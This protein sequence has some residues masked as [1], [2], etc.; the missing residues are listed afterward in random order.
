MLIVFEGLDRSGKT[1]LSKAFC[2]YLNKNP[3]ALNITNFEWTKE[4]LFSTEEADKLNDCKNDEYKREAL[5]FESRIRHQ[6]MMKNKNIICD[7]YIWTGLAYA[8]LFSPLTLPFIKE[9]YPNPNIILQPDLHIFVDTPIDICLER[10][11]TLDANVLR[12]LRKAFY[13]TYQNMKHIRCLIIAS[14]GP[15]NEIIEDL[16]QQIKSFQ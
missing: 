16:I 8:T 2:E 10:D 6:E 13:D 11:S 5:F 1:T 3:E 12:N 4:P 15:I 9:I 14:V 7:R